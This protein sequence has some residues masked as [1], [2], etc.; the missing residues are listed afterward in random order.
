MFTVPGIDRADVE[1][2]PVGRREEGQVDDG[3]CSG[4]VYPTGQRPGS[5]PPVNIVLLVH[6]G[7]PHARLCTFNTRATSS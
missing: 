7:K 2:D 3:H 4:S 1:Y 6:T 5:S